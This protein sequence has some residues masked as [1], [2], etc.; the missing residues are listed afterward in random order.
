MQNYKFI[1]K[2]VIFFDKSCIFAVTIQKQIYYG[3]NFFKNIFNKCLLVQIFVLNL[4]HYGNNGI[5]RVAAGDN[6]ETT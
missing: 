6:E 2:L 4:Q 1:F 3:T 5:K